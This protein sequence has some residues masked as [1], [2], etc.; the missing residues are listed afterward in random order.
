[1]SNDYIERN[2]ISYLMKYVSIGVDS[3]KNTIKME[4]NN[5]GLPWAEG[6]LMRATNVV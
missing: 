1:M 2:V 4:F 3:Q 6:L 5:V